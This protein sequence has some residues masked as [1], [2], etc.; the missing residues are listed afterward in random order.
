M[1]KDSVF[2]AA[3]VFRS[4]TAKIWGLDIHVNVVGGGNIMDQPACILAP[5]SVRTESPVPQNI[6]VTG[7]VSIRSRVKAVGG[8][9]QDLRS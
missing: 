9:L 1:A 8:P 6:A 2:N 5:S 4:L 7:E 3:S